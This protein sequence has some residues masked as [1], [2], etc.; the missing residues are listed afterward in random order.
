MPPHM[1]V[2]MN[3]ALSEMTPKVSGVDLETTKKRRKL[4][5]ALI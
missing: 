3:L 4:F 1:K 2:L 5:A